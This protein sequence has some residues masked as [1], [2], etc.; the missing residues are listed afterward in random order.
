MTYP[1]VTLVFGIF[2]ARTLYRA[3]SY[4]PDSVRVKTPTDSRR[5]VYFV[6]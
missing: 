5:F 3:L 1:K 6:G 4:S 2:C